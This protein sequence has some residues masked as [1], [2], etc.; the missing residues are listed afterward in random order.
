MSQDEKQQFAN[1]QD[2]LVNANTEARLYRGLFW[3]LLV[4]AAAA[5]ILHILQR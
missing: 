4:F 3:T 5:T 1:L 2:Q